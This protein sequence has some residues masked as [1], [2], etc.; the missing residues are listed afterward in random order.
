MSRVTKD[1]DDESDKEKGDNE[2][3]GSSDSKQVAIDRMDI[4]HSNG[5]HGAILFSTALMEETSKQAEKEGNAGEKN[6]EEVS[7]GGEES[8]S[9]KEEEWQDE[10]KEESYLTE[11]MNK[12]SAQLNLGSNDK[13]SDF[14]ENT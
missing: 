10:E 2:M 5:K 7:A 8:E 6:M 4:L 3:D 12:A 14:Q 1:S 9:S 11:K 13:G